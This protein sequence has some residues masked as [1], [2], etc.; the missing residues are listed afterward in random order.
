MVER[1]EEVDTDVEAQGGERQADEELRDQ[2]SYLVQQLDELRHERELEGKQRQEKEQQDKVAAQRELATKQQRAENGCR[3]D[4][5]VVFIMV[6]VI[7]AAVLI[8]ATSKDCWGNAC[9]R[10]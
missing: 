5:V 8:V 9:L 1:K 2:V 10:V 6:V 3:N 4:V 7:V